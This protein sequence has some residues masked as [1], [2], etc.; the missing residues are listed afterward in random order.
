MAAANRGYRRGT[1][2]A[3]ENRMLTGLGVVSATPRS[4]PIQ[5]TKCDEGIQN[6]DEERR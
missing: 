1:K 5:I 4:M 3:G 6:Q 2:R